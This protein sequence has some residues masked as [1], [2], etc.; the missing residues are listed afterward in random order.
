[1]PKVKPKTKAQRDNLM[2]AAITNLQAQMSSLIA[3]CDA[4]G[5]P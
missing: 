2:M 5:G 1:M 4:L 3:S